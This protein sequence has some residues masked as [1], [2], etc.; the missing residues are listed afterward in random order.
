MSK[1]IAKYMN[2][3]MSKRPTFWNEGVQVN[4]LLWEYH[5][6]FLIVEEPFPTKEL[7]TFFFV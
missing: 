7:R 4:T 1:S 2:L 3:E 6:S 5:G